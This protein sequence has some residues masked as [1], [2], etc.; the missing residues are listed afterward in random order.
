MLQDYNDDIRQEQMWEMQVL[1][2][3][4]QGRA[5]DGSAGSA[6]ERLVGDVTDCT[7]THSPQGDENHPAMR[8]I[9]TGKYHCCSV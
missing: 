7:E 9:E 4:K 6:E 3:Q 2:S 8:G 1:S 5:D